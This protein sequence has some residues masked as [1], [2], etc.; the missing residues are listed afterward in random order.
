VEIQLFMPRRLKHRLH[1]PGE[2][3]SKS[4]Q[5]A[6]ECVAPEV[7]LVQEKRESPHLKA[8]S[9]LS[10]SSKWILRSWGRGAI[11]II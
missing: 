3:L 9:F 6:R 2:A 1:M 8:P 4:G 7:A 11:D 5:S 10:F